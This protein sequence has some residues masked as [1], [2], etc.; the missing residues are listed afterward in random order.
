MADRTRDS[1]LR[2]AA[3][4]RRRRRK[5]VPVITTRVTKDDE[6]RAAELIERFGWDHLRKNK[7]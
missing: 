4:I 3:R 1:F 6:R 2:R 5:G 7:A